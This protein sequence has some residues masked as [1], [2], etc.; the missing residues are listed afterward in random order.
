MLYL[1]N[2][3]EEIFNLGNKKTFKIISLTLVS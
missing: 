3:W 2:Y 1:S